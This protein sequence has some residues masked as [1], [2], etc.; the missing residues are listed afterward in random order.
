MGAE[1]GATTSLFP[2]N[3]RMRDY[4]K[5]TRRENIASEADKYATSLL[6]ADANA[7]YDQ[8]CFLLAL[9]Y[10]V[11]SYEAGLISLWLCKEN[12]KLCDW[13][14]VF[15]LYISPRAPHTYDFVVL[16]SLTHPRNILMVV[17]QIR[18]AKD[19]SASLRT[20][21]RIFFCFWKWL[22]FWTPPIN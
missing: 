17:L 16:T 22:I 18:K 1:I 3:S 8:V 13:K 9:W 11:T 14:I 15:T 20:L 19:L 6:T 12:K 5:A 21:T 4:L 7:P 10:G 2:Y